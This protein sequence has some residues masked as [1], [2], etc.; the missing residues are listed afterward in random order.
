MRQKQ[1]C[2]LTSSAFEILKPSV[3]I[4][5][6]M[7]LAKAEPQLENRTLSEHFFVQ[8]TKGHLLH[9][10]VSAQFGLNNGRFFGVS[11]I[12]LHTGQH[13]LCLS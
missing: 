6:T 8:L 1:Y 11:C 10:N 2:S 4:Q 12:Y 7:R 3:E 5:S 13:S 9:H